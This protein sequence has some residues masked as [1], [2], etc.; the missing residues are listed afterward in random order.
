MMKAVKLSPPPEGSPLGGRRWRR[1]KGKRGLVGAA[2]SAARTDSGPGEQTRHKGKASCGLANPFT[3][4]MSLGF[5]GWIISIPPGRPANPGSNGDG[6]DEDDYPP[7]PQSPPP[8]ADDPRAPMVL[9][10]RGMLRAKGKEG[11]QARNA[12]GSRVGAR[13]ELKVAA[14]DGRRLDRLGSLREGAAIWRRGSAF[15]AA[16]CAGSTSQLAWGTWRGGIR[17]RGAAGR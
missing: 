12:A 6:R 3:E 11:K 1:G 9:G 15:A 7:P 4:S 2:G 14:A 10:T 5:R 16:R 8:Q 13:G 17:E